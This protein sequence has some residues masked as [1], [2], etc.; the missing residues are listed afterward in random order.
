M[1]QMSL[2]GRIPVLTFHAETL[3]RNLMEH[4]E[5]QVL[6]FEEHFPLS[7]AQM[8][9][10]RDWWQGTTRRAVIAFGSGNGFCWDPSL[11][12][13]QP[14]ARSFPGVF[15]LIGLKQ[16]KVPQLDSDEPIAIA[17]VS[18]VRRSAFLN[19]T[20]LQDIHKIANVRRVFGSR[21]SVF[22]TK[23]NIKR[24]RSRWLPNGE[25]GIPWRCSA[26]SGWPKALRVPPKRR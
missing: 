15:E 17:D 8:L 21:A 6:V 20:D 10:I 2:S 25:I 9:V 22:G 3:E 14:C 19:A 23:R 12:E 5:V 26:A 11:A 1:K 18:R 13:S 7:V 16:E 24:R 4:P